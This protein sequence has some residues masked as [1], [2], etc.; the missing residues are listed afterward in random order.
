MNLCL[1]K[2]LRLFIIMDSNFALSW[3]KLTETIK[4]SFILKDPSEV[5]KTIETLAT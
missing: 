3:P 5:D 4:P 1:N 2:S